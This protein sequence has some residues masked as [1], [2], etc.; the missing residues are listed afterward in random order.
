MRAAAV[1]EQQPVEAPPVEARPA[2]GSKASACG[3]FGTRGR[4]STEPLLAARPA[5]ESKARGHRGP[6]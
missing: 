4:G 6:W 3:A 1:A 2:V 5:G